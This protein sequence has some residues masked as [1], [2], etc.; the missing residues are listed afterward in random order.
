MAPDT[1]S[2]RQRRKNEEAVDKS[3]RLQSGEQLLSNVKCD[4]L[5]NPE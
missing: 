1:Y 4:L 3:H 5:H 2:L